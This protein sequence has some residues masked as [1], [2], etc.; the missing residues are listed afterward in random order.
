MT[1]LEIAVYVAVMSGASPIICHLQDPATTACSNGYVAK[2]LSLDTIRFG[3]GVTVKRD[4]DRFPVFSNGLKS[5]LS[6]NGWLQF[7]NGIGVRRNDGDVYV[8]TNGLTCRTKL[9]DLIDCT[10]PAS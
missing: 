1:I 10:R 8:F 2:A 6:G 7:S 5:T 9:P 3:N 4:G